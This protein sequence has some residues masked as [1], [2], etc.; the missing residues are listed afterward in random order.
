MAFAWEER[1]W[2]AAQAR[3]RP[4]GTKAFIA[5]VYFHPLPSCSLSLF[6]FSA[7]AGSVLEER[8]RDRGLHLF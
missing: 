8:K 6:L 5:V 1:E 7:L 3:S 4:T 2:L